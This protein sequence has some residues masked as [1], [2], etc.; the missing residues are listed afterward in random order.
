M[1]FDAARRGARQRA[2][3]PDPAKRRDIAQ[4]ITDEIIAL[5]ESGDGLPWR[6]P[7]KRAGGGLPLRHEGSPYRGINVFM[8]GLRAMTRGYA[9]PYWMSYRQATELGG[10][11]RKGEKS[12]TVVYYGVG[13]NRQAD[14]P[15]DLPAAT[16]RSDGDGGD[17]AYRFLKWFPAFNADQ[18]DGLPHR[19]HPAADDLDGG[20]RPIAELAAVAHAM[21]AGLGVDYIEGGDRACF[22]RDLDQIRMPHITRFHDAERFYATVFHEAAHATEVP[23]R[24]KLDYGAKAFGNE[25]YARGELYAEMTAAM[26]GATLGFTPDHLEDHAA[27]LQSWLKALRNDKRFVLKAAAD[28]QRGADYLLKAAGLQTDDALA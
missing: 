8:L 7:W 18:I 2:F 26:L 6:M 4:E 24:L 28:A 3:T 13:K 20:A 22:V 27:Y 9:S 16:D 1:P 5:L 14:T 19:Y 10:Q 17:S 12:S 11:V 25:A 21:I 23:K 15:P